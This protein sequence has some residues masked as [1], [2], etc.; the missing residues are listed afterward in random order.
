MTLRDISDFHRVTDQ[1]RRNK[2]KL[3]V[4]IGLPL[5]IVATVAA[6]FTLRNAGAAGSAAA[7]A[8]PNPDCTLVVPAN[9]LTATGL[10]TP[11]QLSATKNSAGR[12][13][14]ANTAQSAFVEATILDPATGALSVYRPLIID[15]R[16]RAAVTPSAP[17]LPNGAVVG[18][19]FGFN[20]NNLTLGGSGAAQCVNGLRGSLFSQ[21][22]NCNGQTF[23]TAANKA[24]SQGKLTVPQLGTAKDGKP[25][26]TTRDFG[27]VDQDQSDNVNTSYLVM[28]DGRIAQNTTANAAKLTNAQTLVNGSDNLLLDQFVDPALGCRPFTVP[29]LT[30]PGSKVSSLALDELFAAARQ[31]APAAL[32]PLNDPMTEVNGSYSTAKT[33]LYRSGV[34]QLP[35]GTAGEWPSQYCRDLLTIGIKRTQLDKAMTSAAPSPD[36]AAGNN[37]FT[38][39]AQRLAG[40]FTNLGCDKLLHIADPVHLKTD[41]A[42]VTISATFSTP[43][44]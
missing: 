37:L 41:K 18:L 19:W 21:V 20:G 11:Y 36:P 30:N 6:V 40:S 29:D 25:C 9:P 13:H 1:R 16:S 33:N 5:A 22:A 35:V 42:G 3:I 23:F 26:M 24:I 43:R 12:C 31:G 34:D 15:G 27:L 39:L 32:V 38:F 28:P 10:A 4:A 2:A 8:V 7:D 17:K 14:E 44:F